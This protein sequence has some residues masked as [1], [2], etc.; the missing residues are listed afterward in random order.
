MVFIPR[1]EPFVCEHC[2]AVVEPLS[3]GTYRNHCPHCLWSKHVDLEGPGDRRSSCGALMRPVGLDQ[4]AKK[5]FVLI[6]RCERCAKEIA[7]KTA[8]D[9]DLSAFPP[10]GCP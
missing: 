1:Q 9:D 2:G 8:P 5:G 10:E 3:K 6:H 4:R 7:N